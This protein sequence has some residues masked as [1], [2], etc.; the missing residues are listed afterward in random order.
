MEA[1]LV[2]ADYWDLVTVVWESL[3][4]VHRARG[5]S[6]CLQLRRH[7]ITA[8]MIEGQTMESWIGEVQ[9]RTR[10]LENIDITVSDEDMIVILTA[11]LPLSYTPVII[12]FNAL[13]PEKVTLNFV[14]NCLLNEEA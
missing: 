13:N 7:F 3:V 9:T 6:S 12:S 4:K 14:I 1:I 10:H 8:T 2:R 11:G 5:F